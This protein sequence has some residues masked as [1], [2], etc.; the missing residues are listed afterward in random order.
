MATHRISLLGPNTMPDSSGNCWQDLYSRL[1]TND[2]WPYGVFNFGGTISNN[3]APTT[4]IGL[5]GQVAIP[6]N[7]VGTAKVVVVWTSTLTSGDAVWDFDYRAITGND[8]ES[9]DQ[10]G[11][12]ESVSV[13]DTAPGAAH[14]RLECTANLTS[15]NL[16]AGDSMEWG[17]FRDG[18][19]AA[20][21]LAG[22][23][24]LVDVLLEYADV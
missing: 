23:A 13:T 14:R 2:V 17:L 10:S 5:Y 1:A 9:L 21:T 18:T 6:Q 11:T 24:I 8:S 20:D 19:D 22:T 4:R 16:A 15:A 7:Y 12:Q 3:T